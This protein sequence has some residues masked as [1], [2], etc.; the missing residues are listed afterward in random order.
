V[1]QNKAIEKTS[2][3]LFIWCVLNTKSNKKQD[4]R[5]V[6]CKKNGKKKSKQGVVIGCNNKRE[7]SQTI[8]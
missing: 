7:G 4:N 6:Q 3:M 5:E 1:K 2:V 8:E